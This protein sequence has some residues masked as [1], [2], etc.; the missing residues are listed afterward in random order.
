M[1]VMFSALLLAAVSAFAEPDPALH[2]LVKAEG[3]TCKSVVERQCKEVTAAFTVADGWVTCW[4]KITGQTG[5]VIHHIWYKDDKK[6]DAREMKVAG[7]PWRVWSKKQLFP[8]SKG[9]WRVEILDGAGVPIQ[10][11]AFTVR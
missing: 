11:V 6:I 8:E 2:S 7:S 9:S 5:G 10:T 1:A 3:M 4:S